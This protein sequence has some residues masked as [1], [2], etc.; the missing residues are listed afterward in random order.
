MCHRLLCYGDS[1]TYGYDPRS[2]LGGRYPETV[3]WTALLNAKGWPVINKGENGRSI[4][5]LDWEINTAIRI[6]CPAEADALVVMLGSNDL[7]QCPGITAEVCGGRMGKFLSAVLEEAQ[8]RL[9]VLLAVPPPM[10]P[11]AWVSDPRT[12]EESQRLAS[13][14]RAV[15][16]RLGIAFA[17]AGNWNVELAYDGVHFSAKG[18][19]AF[20]AGIGAALDQLF[21][22]DSH[23]AITSDEIFKAAH[24][25]N[26]SGQT[27][28]TS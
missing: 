10:E 7:L 12:M 1:N 14:Y 21:C 13:C 24:P 19:Q 26:R 18:H 15:T 6:I 16:R 20:A 4:P 27:V 22:S 2:Y 5:R 11:G 28:P 25:E 9:K 23:E 17:D 8:E 3:R